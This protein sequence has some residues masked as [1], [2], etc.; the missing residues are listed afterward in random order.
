MDF[1]SQ[2]L[3][4]GEVVVWSGELEK[5]RHD[6]QVKPAPPIREEHKPRMCRQPH[7]RDDECSKVGEF[8]INNRK[9]IRAL[10]Q[11]WGVKL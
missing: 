7:V 6:A 5:Q 8:S 11:K 10:R 2:A 3:R 1:S 9:A 4:S